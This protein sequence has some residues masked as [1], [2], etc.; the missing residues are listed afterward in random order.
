MVKITKPG[1]KEFHGF[2]KWCG[3]EFTYEISDL[4]LSAT[5]DKVSCP[6]CGKDYHHP[7]MIQDPTIPG[8]IGYR[9][10]Q[11]ITWPLGDSIPCT[12]DMTKSDPCAGCVWRE[13]LLRDGLYV[14]DTP[15]TWCNKNKF[16]C[17][18]S[19]GSTLQSGSYPKAHLAD[20][21]SSVSS[22]S[23]SCNAGTTATIHLDSIITD[24]VDRD[25]VNK[26]IQEVYNA[27][28]CSTLNK[29]ETCGVTEGKNSCHNN[30]KCT[31]NK[32]CRSKH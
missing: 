23:S 28:G 29:C 5:S 25:Y 4:K 3:C 16:S 27:S 21:V 32:N 24:Q 19:S 17:N 10:L 20:T 26:K 11:D 2:C 30:S 13:N 31:G 8:G 6:T 1:Q 15:C 22:L 7:S 18:I 12:P 14:G 9:G